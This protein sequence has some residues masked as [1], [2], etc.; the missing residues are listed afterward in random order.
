MVNI[1]L[2]SD[3][4]PN[5]MAPLILNPRRHPSQQGTLTEGEGFVRL[6]SLLNSLSVKKTGKGHFDNLF[7]IRENTFFSV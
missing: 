4:L 3:I 7:G 2:L 5:V 1:L 6:T